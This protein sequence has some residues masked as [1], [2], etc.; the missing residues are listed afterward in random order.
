MKYLEVQALVTLRFV[1]YREILQ[2]PGYQTVDL[3]EIASLTLRSQ[4]IGENLVDFK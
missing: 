3:T 1:K 2:S 4:P